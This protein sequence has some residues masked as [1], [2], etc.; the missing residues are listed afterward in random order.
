MPSPTAFEPKIVVVE[1]LLE[2]DDP[3]HPSTV[4][5]PAFAVDRTRAPVG[6]ALG[7]L[8]RPDHAGNPVLA[9]DD[10]RVG[11]QAAAVGHDRPEQRQED[12][13]RLGRRLGDEDVAL[14]DAVELGGMR[15]AAR[16]PFVD[17]RLAASPRSM[18]SSCA[19][20]SCRTARSSAMPDRAHHARRGGRQ[21]TGRAEGRRRPASRGFLRVCDAR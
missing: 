2:R 9:R 8:A 14:D 19:P 21:R 16:R 7:R 18:C 11:E 1:R 3:F 15:D 13:E 17:A 10:R 20:R 5:S 6:D 4:T 12:V